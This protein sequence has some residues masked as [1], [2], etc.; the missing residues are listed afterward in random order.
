MAD[1]FGVRVTSELNVIDTLIICNSSGGQV[2]PAVA[3][4][5]ANFIV[6]WADP[7][8]DD[9]IAGIKVAQVTPQGAVLDTG[10]Y[11]G[12]GSSEPDVAFGVDECFAVWPQDFHGVRG[13]FIDNSGQPVDTAFDITSI[14]GSTTIPKVAFGEDEFLVVWADFCSTGTDL[15]I[16][17]QLVSSQ[18]QLIGNR[19]SIAEGS[20]NQNL[21]DCAFDGT[22]FLVAWS[23][24][25]DIFGQLITSSGQ[26]LGPQF[27]IS[28]DTPFIRGSPSVS[29]GMDNFLVVWDEYHDGFDIYGNVDILISVE[30]E[31]TLPSGTEFIPSIITHHLRLSNIDSFKIYDISGRRVELH[32]MVPGVYFIEVNHRVIKKVVKIR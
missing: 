3:F 23:E 26:L 6:V 2:D 9:F 11:V 24:G 17:G 30:E 5:G 32:Q 20:Q 29:T 10:Y 15:D 28:D 8:Y 25:P 27:Q 16:Y 19:I 12:V 13:R 18:G 22:D 14:I 1:I 21:P 4:N 7:S 31:E